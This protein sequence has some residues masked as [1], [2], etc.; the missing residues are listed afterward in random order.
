MSENYKYL[1]SGFVSGYIS[2]F[3]TYPLDTIK[4]W[5]QTNN[6]INLN[7]KNLYRGNLFPCL[8]SGCINSLMFSLNNNINKHTNNQFIS[9]GI[10]GLFIGFITTPIEYYKIQKQS[11]VK[12]ININNFFRGLNS[13]ILRESLS[14][15]IYFG[16]YQQFRELKLNP[17]ISGG[18]CG[19]SSWIMTYP[20]DVVKTRIQQNNNLTYLKAIK[21]GNLWSGIMFCCAR[22]FLNNGIVF[23]TFENI[24][25]IF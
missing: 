14:I 24:L 11:N 21:Q 9:G 15:S 4:V 5:K 20:I 1:I 12:K 22:S 7:I 16:S 17:V 18:L 25:K 2:S 19:I 3:S 10:T 23:Y 13:T 8:T 6:N